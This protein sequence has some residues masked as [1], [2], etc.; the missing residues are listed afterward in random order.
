MTT[1]VLTLQVT[2]ITKTNHHDPCHRIAALGGGSWYYS[3]AKVIQ[4][5]KSRQTE[6]FTLVNGRRANVVVAKNPRTGLEYVKTEADSYEPNN[7]LALPEC[8]R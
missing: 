5:I 6:F 7:L 1:Q 3:V 4:L 2:C 8:R